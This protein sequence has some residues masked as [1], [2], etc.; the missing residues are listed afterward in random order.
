MIHQQHRR[1]TPVRLAFAALLAA[2]LAACGGG[3]SD[4]A[5][6]TTAAP[7]A[8]ALTQEP[9]APVLT[10]NTAIDGMNWI[11]YRRSQIGASVLV[12]NTSLDRSAQG[13]S[14]YQRINNKVTHDQVAGLP[15]FTGV[16]LRS[17]MTAAGYLL[18]NTDFAYGEVISATSNPS[19]FYMAEE[20]ITAIYHRFVI[21]EP[22]FKEVGTGYAVN[23]SN[24]SYFTTNFAANNGLGAGLGRGNVVHWPASGQTKVTPNFFSDFEEPDPIPNVNEVGYP[25]SVHAD[26]KTVLNVQSFTIRPRGGSELSVKLLRDGVDSYTPSS[27]AAIIPLLPLKAATVY[28]VTFAG[29][30]DNLVVNKSWSFTTK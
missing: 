6:S 22:K 25:I 24:Y 28:D 7:A 9:G 18:A 19:G 5:P 3:G 15:G 12:R 20:L 29:T 27:A 23:S 16:D 26:L 4:K 8:A 2:A 17:R 10:N 11:N 21:F 13:H 30:A 1:T 14:D